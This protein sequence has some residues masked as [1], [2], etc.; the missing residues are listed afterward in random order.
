MNLLDT[1]CLDEESEEGEAQHLRQGNDVELLEIL[2]KLV[3]VI[4]G[5]GLHDDAARSIVTASRITSTI[6][7]AVSLESQSVV[8][9]HGQSVMDAV[10]MVVAFAPDEFRGIE[11]GDDIEEERR[12]AFDS[13]E[14]E[15]G[16]WPNVCLRRARRNGRC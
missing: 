12:A 16:D 13:L 1:M 15:I 10:E 14:H 6:T 9:L 2:Q 11:G 4:A 8:S 3:M 7:M 5:D